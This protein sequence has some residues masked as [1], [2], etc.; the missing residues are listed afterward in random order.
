MIETVG[1]YTR[2]AAVRAAGIAARLKQ[3]RAARHRPWP[4][5]DF[6]IV[7]GHRYP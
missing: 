7:S 4:S 6:E 1:A 2:T 3:Q 5:R